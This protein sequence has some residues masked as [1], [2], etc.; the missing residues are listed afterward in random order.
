MYV[1]CSSMGVDRIDPLL[2][3]VTEATSDPFGRHHPAASHLLG[4]RASFQPS[5]A[6]QPSRIIRKQSHALTGDTEYDV[7]A[8]WIGVQIVSIHFTEKDGIVV[9]LLAA[10]T[11]QITPCPSPGFG[12]EPVHKVASTAFDLKSM[13]A[14]RQDVKRLSVPLRV[15]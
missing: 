8:L 6:S 5:N 10:R 9:L 15:S 11:E 7:P 13:T 14:G 4:R 1:S 3:G 12:L 2:T